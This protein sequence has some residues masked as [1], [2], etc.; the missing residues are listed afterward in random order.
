MNF[1]HITTPEQWAKFQDKNY[2]EAESLHTE[3]FIH[4]SYT[5]QLEETLALHYKNVP[6][7]FLLD[8]N[9]SRLQVELKV[10]ESRGGA[11]FPHIYGQMN[12]SAIDRIVVRDLPV[13]Q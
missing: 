4:G 6:Q 3:G 11:F 10:E 9:P 2:F 7:V 1:Y 13:G 8:I 12:K 5:A